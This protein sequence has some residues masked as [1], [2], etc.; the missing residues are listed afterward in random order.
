M[1]Q[2]KNRQK[3]KLLKILLIGLSL[4]V[5]STIG[6]VLYFYL[7]SLEFLQNTPIVAH[8]ALVATPTLEEYKKALDE[9]EIVY[10]KVEYLPDESGIKIQIQDGPEV[11][12]SSSKD[13]SYQISSLQSILTHSTIDNK[14]PKRIDFRFVKPIVNF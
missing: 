7:R 10:E 8:T 11:F 12:V 1:R 3:G 9:K 6:S 2:K 14:K 4:A 5:I 13:L